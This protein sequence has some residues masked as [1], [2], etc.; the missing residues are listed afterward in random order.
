MDTYRPAP[1]FEGSVPSKHSRRVA[2][3]YRPPSEFD[4]PPARGLVKGSVPAQQRLAPPGASPFRS[5]SA[6]LAS[7]A[8]ESVM[9]G[10]SC[11]LTPLGARD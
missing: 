5:E 2:G 3:V 8:S 10:P 1:G 4:R 7:A 11:S 6:A 9:T